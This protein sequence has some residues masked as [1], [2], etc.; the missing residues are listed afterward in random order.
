MKYLKKLSSLTLTAVIAFSFIISS[1]ATAFAESD[2]RAVIKGVRPMSM[3]GAFIAVSDDENAFFYNPAGI[4]QRQGWLLQLFSLDIA[5]NSETFS[6]AKFYLDNRNDLE[7]FNDLTPEQQAD[8]IKKINNEIIGKVPNVMVALP[9][10]AF[11]SAPV[12]IFD[13]QLSF[14]AGL[15]TYAN[16]NFQFNRTLVPS[17]SY[18]GEF[19]GLLSVP[20][21]Y[22]INSLDAINMP[23]KLS[24]GAN[25]KYI[26]RGKAWDDELSVAEFETLN[27][28]PMQ[29]GSGFGLDLGLLYSL[30]TRWNFGLQLTDAFYTSIHYDKFDNGEYPYRNRDSYTSGIRPEWNIG[31]A[32]VPERIYYWPDKYINTNNRFTF[33]ADITD[34]ANSDETIT[35]SFFKK[36]HFGGEFKLS[37][38]AI[39]AGF[40]SGYPTVGAAIA[41]NV[42]QFEYAFYGQE[43]GRYAGQDASWFHRIQFSVKIGENKGKAYGKDAKKQ[44]EPSSKKKKEPKEKSKPKT[45]ETAATAD[46][47]LEPLKLPSDAKETISKPAQITEMK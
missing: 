29:T 44:R 5:V 40:N 28:L 18:V 21:A 6:F 23:G 45:K 20:V 25:L 38:F 37:P 4:T 46:T 14:G 31:A 36:L 17:F 32:Y 2:N 13:N 30:N 33:A 22:K 26:Y 15:F 41:S 35:D 1:T 47:S 10:L 12:N 7:N 11:I 8:L 27:K 34:I 16:A 19:T 3:G 24:V 43:E 9:D 39:R 42:V